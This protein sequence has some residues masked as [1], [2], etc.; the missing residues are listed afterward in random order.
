VNEIAAPYSVSLP[1]VSRHV[2]LLERAGM[3]S[4]RVK[5]PTHH[6]SLSSHSLA[7][8]RRWLDIRLSD[9]VARSAIQL[10]NRAGH[11][12]G[13]GMHP[14]PSPA[15]RRGLR[16]RYRALEVRRISSG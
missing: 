1:A 12:A 11:G 6:L 4:R 3:I 14:S 13:R 9:Q 10:G 2:K 8:A 15:F 7:V 5:G 16:W